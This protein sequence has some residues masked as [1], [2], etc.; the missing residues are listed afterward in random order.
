MGGGGSG[1]NS[2]TKNEAAKWWRNENTV[3]VRP[4]L[5]H[6]LCTVYSEFSRLVERK[7]IRTIRGSVHHLHAF[8][9]AYALAAF[10]K[11]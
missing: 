1:E 4:C 2:K 10:S 11:V 3:V 9:F 6:S 7:N 8:A 5:R